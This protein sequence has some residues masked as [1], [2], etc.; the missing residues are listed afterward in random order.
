MQGFADLMM[1]WPQLTFI[2]ED[3]D[4]P[5]D[6]VIAWKRR[7]SIPFE[8]WQGMID[9]A[10]HRGIEGV[11][12]EVMGNALEQLRIERA[13]ERQSKR[14]SNQHRRPIHAPV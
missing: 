1:L 3:L 13:R 6:T 11:T 2:S 12:Y 5:Y 8:Y 14:G 4:V 9:S 10:R 7:N